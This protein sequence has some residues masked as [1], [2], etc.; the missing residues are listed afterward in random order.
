MSEESLSS[1]KRGFLMYFVCGRDSLRNP[2]ILS[3]LIVSKERK[4]SVEYG[5]LYIILFS[6]SSFSLISLTFTSRDLIS[7]RVPPET[8]TLFSIT[9][10]KFVLLFPAT[11]SV[12]GIS[13]MSLFILMNLGT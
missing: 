6:F 7:V 12:T 10:L 13:R 8:L 2:A 3:S 5:V 1:F 4:Y 9:S 11:I